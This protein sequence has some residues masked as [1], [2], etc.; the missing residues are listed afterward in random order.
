MRDNT[1]WISGKRKKVRCDPMKSFISGV[2]PHSRKHKIKRHYSKVWKGFRKNNEIKISKQKI[3]FKPEIRVSIENQELCPGCRQLECRCKKE[4]MVNVKVPVKVVMNAVCHNLCG[5]IILTDQIP[6]L[7]IWKGS[8]CNDLILSISVYNSTLSK[9]SICV[10]VEGTVG[11][12]QKF[13]VPPGNTIT[14]TIE[15]AESIRVVRI[16]ETK[17]EG[18]FCLG[19]SFFSKKKPSEFQ[20]LDLIKT[21]QKKPAD[22]NG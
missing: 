13:I 3:E 19:I 22:H 5:N 8:L 2:S 11:R 16:G 20:C 9:A 6:E 4:Q 17:I 18:K 7:E 14:A 1:E 12:D 10:L 21:K 15:G